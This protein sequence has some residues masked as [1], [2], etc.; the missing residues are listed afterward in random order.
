M[1]LSKVK[2]RILLPV[3][4]LVGSIALTRVG[5]QRRITVIDTVVSKWG[6]LHEP[7]PEAVA[8]ERFAAYAISG[9]AW[10]AA[11]EIPNLIR[12]NGRLPNSLQSIAF[13]KVMWHDG[14]WWF[15]VFLLFMWFLIGRVIDQP[16]NVGQSSVSRSPA[17]RRLVW[18]SSCTLYGLFVCRTA[19]KYWE[20]EYPRWFL[21]SVLAWGVAL[22]VAGLI[23]ALWLAYSR[24]SS[25]VPRPSRG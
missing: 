11:W 23:A 19:L 14:Q 7:L 18:W 17:K 4:F 10:A 13:G 21:Y 15:F 6:S 20:W 5:E 24:Y 8:T 16:L 2:F 1:S 12:V 25:S 9:P 22:A 3:I